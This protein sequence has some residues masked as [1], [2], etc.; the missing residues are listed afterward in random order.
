M[1]G[2][3]SHTIMANDVY[4][5]INKDI[6]K[7]YI[8]TFSL[9]GDLS[10]YAK[11]RYE[12][13]HKYLNEFIYNMADYIKDNNLVKDR[14]C[15]G[16]LYAHVCHYIMD[17]T[18]HPLIRKID[19]TCIKDKH[20]HTMIELYYDYYLVKKYY[21]IR[22]DKYNNKKVLNAKLSQKIKKMIDYT[23]Y[24]T[25]NTKHVSRY[26]AINLWLYRKIKYLYYLFNF[27]FLKKISGFDKFKNV[28]KDIDLV[29]TS[30]AVTYK[31]YLGNESKSDLITLYRECI[32]RA[33][34]YI[35]KLDKYLD[36]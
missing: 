16:V 6:N 5:R 8:L 22:L 36:E 31:D 3:V 32:D 23:Y 30:H 17:D 2:Y 14:D 35:S 26:Y 27:N 18:I 21:N 28:N 29:N 20:N 12:T 34:D 25:Y 1:P 24:K 11:C 19:K 10:K 15:L 33:I 4:K 9:G 7:D 13:H